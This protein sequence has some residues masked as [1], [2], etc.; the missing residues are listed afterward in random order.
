[1]DTSE[2]NKNHKDSTPN[3]LADR[4][5]DNFTEP[6]TMPANWNLSEL[7]TPQRFIKKQGELPSTASVMQP[8]SDCDQDAEPS[9]S[10]ETLAMQPE[11]HRNPF[12]KPRTF[13]FF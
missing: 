4:M 6:R 13:P 10:Q 1:M 5:F 2:Q 11:S 12:P 7:V 8:D 3:I 9:E